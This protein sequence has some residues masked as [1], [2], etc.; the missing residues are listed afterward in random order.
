MVASYNL[1][2]TILFWAFYPD[3]LV[4][5]SAMVL[6]AS[7]ASLFFPFKRRLNKQLRES[8]GYITTA[9]LSIFEG[10]TKT[11]YLK[12]NNWNGEEKN[13]EQNE[14]QVDPSFYRKNCKA[15]VILPLGF[16]RTPI[17][18]STEAEKIEKYGNGIFV[19]TFEWGMLDG[20]VDNMD[21]REKY[22]KKN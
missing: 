3:C 4:L 17:I 5:F 2:I 18:I 22:C 21:L 15:L 10:R 1:V 6:T 7:F 8:G 14:S 11:Y 9:Q 20:F 19:D 12:L 13:F 16:E